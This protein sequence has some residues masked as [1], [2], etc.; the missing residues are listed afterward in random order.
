[1][2]LKPND[3]SL[4]VFDTTELHAQAAVDFA[5]GDSIAFRA[6]A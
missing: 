4:P 3:V 5:L 6:V 1:M 2:S